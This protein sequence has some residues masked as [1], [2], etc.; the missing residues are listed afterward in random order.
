MAWVSAC[1]AVKLDDG[2][3]VVVDRKPEPPVAVFNVSGDF[4]AVDDTCTHEEYS[5]ADGYID[6]DIVEC[7]LH[8][9]KF[10]ICTG[11]A[12]SLPA[13]ANLA[14]YPV[15]VEDGVVFVDL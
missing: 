6:G 8:M 4:Y 11:K 9:A 15:K 5:L 13:T 2:E 7:P 1:E 12:L 10:S 3:A 14:A